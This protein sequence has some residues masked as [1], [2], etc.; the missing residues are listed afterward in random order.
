M[1]PS[2]S[3]IQHSTTYNNG[4]GDGT[5]PTIH[6]V[7]HPPTTH[8]KVDDSNKYLAARV[9]GTSFERNTG[10]G[11]EDDIIFTTRHKSGDKLYLVLTG[12][13]LSAD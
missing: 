12:T 10:L 4:D 13:G 5:T 3:H 11:W 2:D 8:T 9:A 6:I 7:Y 1:V